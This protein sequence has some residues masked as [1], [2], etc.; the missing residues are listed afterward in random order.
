M[1]Q[2]LGICSKKYDSNEKLINW[3]GSTRSPCRDP[4]P[5]WL[6]L[7]PLKQVPIIPPATAI[8]SAANSCNQRAQIAES[9][10]FKHWFTGAKLQKTFIWQSELQL[11]TACYLNVQY[12]PSASI[13]DPLAYR[14]QSVGHQ[15]LRKTSCTDQ[16]CHEYESSNF[17]NQN[18]RRC[19][20]K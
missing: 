14:H 1:I 16:D 15:T 6:P 18:L 12:H 19:S 11:A 4:K 8:F 13:N 2:Y 5:S 7:L 3:S 9:K 10:C 20:W 17:Q